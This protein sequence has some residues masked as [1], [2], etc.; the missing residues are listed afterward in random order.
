M[1]NLRR[2]VGVQTPILAR[3]DWMSRVMTNVVQLSSDQNPEKLAVY[4]GLYYSHTQ[5]YGD[6]FISHYSWIPIIM[7]GQPTP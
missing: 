5:L 7:T 4:R 3:Y 6:Y 1:P 2:C